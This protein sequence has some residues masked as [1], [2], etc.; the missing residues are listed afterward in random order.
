[1][2]GSQ[3]RIALGTVGPNVVGPPAFASTGS[4]VRVVACGPFVPQ[5]VDGAERT[6]ASVDGVAA[7]DGKAASSLARNPPR[8][9]TP[10]RHCETV[11]FDVCHEVL[12]VTDDVRTSRRTE[13]A[14]ARRTRPMGT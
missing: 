13:S 2:N 1:M 11:G 8:L 7:L 9:D 3:R 14:E 6:N 10:C 4:G 5:L 12:A